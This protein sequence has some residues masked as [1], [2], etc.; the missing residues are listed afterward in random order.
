VQEFNGRVRL[1][2]HPLVVDMMGEQ[3]IIDCGSDG[4]PLGG[5]E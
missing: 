5:S 2:V 1:A 4:K 3:G